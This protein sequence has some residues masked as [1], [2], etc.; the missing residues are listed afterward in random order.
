MR[1]VAVVNE[2]PAPSE[3]FIARKVATL[4]GLGAQVSVAA[5]VHRGGGPAVGRVHLPSSRSPR[6][7]LGA[8]RDVIGGD[9]ASRR[10]PSLDLLRRERWIAPI[11]AGHFD[12]VHF[13]FSGIAVKALPLLGELRPARLVVSCRGAGEQIVP[14]RDPR[15]GEQLRQVFEVVDGIH[16]VSDDMAATVRALGAPAE[17]ILVNRPAVDAPRWARLAAGRQPRPDSVLRVVSVGRLHWKKGL[18]DALRAIAMARAA[19]IDV[20]YRI[21]GDGAEMEKLTFLRTQLGLDEVVELVGWQDEVAVEGHLAWAD[22]FLLP[23]L[24]EGISNAAL[25]AMASGLPVISTDCGGMAEVISPGV[26]GLVVGVGRTTDMADAIADLADPERRAALG[27]AA[28][29]VIVDRHDLLG[30]GQRFVALY[31]RLL[32]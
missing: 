8:A 31:E 21:V 30:Q 6:S 22:V 17:K 7:W 9:G 25:E 26:D 12:V 32:G 3:T 28:M 10:L 29:A 4:A 14:L 27:R 5:W 20:A 23:S 18:D 1:V 13:E 19:G 2:F 16:C 24:S 11:A 15:R